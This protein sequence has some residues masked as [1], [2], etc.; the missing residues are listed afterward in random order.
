MVTHL[1]LRRGLDIAQFGARG[2]DLGFPRA[3]V[4]HEGLRERAQ[5]RELLRRAP[6][7][8][9]DAREAALDPLALTH[10]PLAL[11]HADSI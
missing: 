1:S 8:S 10:E 4:L 3:L 6:E 7:L 2:F 11:T 5:E 9:L